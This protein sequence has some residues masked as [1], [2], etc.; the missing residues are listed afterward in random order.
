MGEHFDLIVIGSGPGGYVAAIKASQLGKKT[1][2][3][4]NRELGGTCLN[5]GCIP[6]KTLMHSSRLYYEAK[7]L[8]EAG[9]EID[10][11]R[12]NM[13]KIQERKEEVVLR[14]RKGIKGLLEANKV[15]VIHGT[16]T[17]MDNQKV[18]VKQVSET[19]NST[20][21]E[22]L[23]HSEHKFSLLNWAK[24]L[25]SADNI[26]IA[27]GSK[28]FLPPIE[29][30]EQENVITSDDL[31][32]TREFMY[33]KL[34]IIGGGVIGVEFA[35]IYQELG[36]QVEIIEAM[37]RILPSMD[38]EISQSLAMSL[39]KKGVKIH[40]KAV[41]KKISKT[42]HLLCEYEDSTGIHLAEGDGILVAVGRKANTC[43]LF[44]PDFSLEME[45]DK[46]KV[47]E[48]FETSKKHIYAIG[49][50]IKGI[51]LAHS[52]SAQGIAA[53]ENMFGKSQNIDLSI[54]PSCIYTAPEVAS[55]GLTEEDAK[56]KG[57][58]VKIGKYPMLGNSKTILSGDERGYIKVVCDSNNNR[59]LGAQIICRRATD[60][61]GEFSTAITNGLTINDMRKVIRP[62]PTYGEAI[63]EA[64]EDVDNRAIHILPKSQK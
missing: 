17:I 43:E 40:T 41:V 54:I 57:Y 22:D 37:D 20:S 60:M 44:D 29:G 62:H 11:L 23:C 5:R 3:I 38:K 25:L 14:I 12:F 30:I 24:N 7:N 8:Q 46:V 2:L 31:L 59:I 18:M 4:E 27:T 32:T 63:T 64:I 47:N 53:V 26:L 15:T 1:A 48:Y 28:P 56:G 51:Q 50:V 6:T 10:G 49:D 45:G 52:A 58:M 19:E 34:I 16:A 42:D 13:N 61:I 35:S 33:H 39:K 9:I 21:Q 55:V 36:S